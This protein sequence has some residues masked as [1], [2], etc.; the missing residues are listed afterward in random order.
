MSASMRYGTA[1]VVVLALVTLALWPFLEP[2]GRRGVLAAAL[3]ALPVQ[4]AAFTALVRFKGQAK[5]F[6]A[7]WAGGMALR[8]SALLVVTF[9]VVRSGAESAIPMLLALVGFF[10][11]LL[12]LEGVFFRAAPVTAQRG[13]A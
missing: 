11:A 1:S 5:G 9:L 12:L 7:A 6:M 3:V 4:I 10:F 13:A 2:A 8:A